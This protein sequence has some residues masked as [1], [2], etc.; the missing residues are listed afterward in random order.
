[1]CGMYRVGFVGSQIAIYEHALVTCSSIRCKHYIPPTV[2]C[3][4]YISR[5]KYTSMLVDAPILSR[6]V[7]HGLFRQ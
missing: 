6:H 1:M 7:P 4:T 2:K 5:Y 3:V